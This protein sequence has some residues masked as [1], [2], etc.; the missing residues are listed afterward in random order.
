MRSR[1]ACP[2]AVEPVLP[3][4]DFS[5]GDVVVPATGG[6]AKLVAFQSMLLSS[7][8]SDYCPCLPVPEATLLAPKLLACL[9]G[10]SSVQ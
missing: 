8:H 9:G 6:F 4:A 3:W 5:N 10:T 7:A 2:L 1:S